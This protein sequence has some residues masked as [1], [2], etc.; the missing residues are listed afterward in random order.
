MRITVHPSCKI[1]DK[2]FLSVRKINKSYCKY[3]TNNILGYK[4][5]VSPKELGCNLVTNKSLLI[6]PTQDSLS[7][8]EVYDF[9]RG[10]VKLMNFFLFLGTLD[11]TGNFVLFIFIFRMRIIVSVSTGE[12]PLLRVLTSLLTSL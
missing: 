2:S 6:R 12:S 11:D 3:S 9:S 1:I 8:H 7:L 5:T 10:F 4:R